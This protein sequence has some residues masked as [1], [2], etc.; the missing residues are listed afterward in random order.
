MV[1]LSAC[2]MLGLTMVPQAWAASDKAPAAKV[3][4][5]N[6]PLPKDI[7][8]ATSFAP[9]VK[10]VAPSVVNIYTSK[11]TR[12]NPRMHPLFNDPLFERFFGPG[13]RGQMQPRERTERSLGSGVIVSAD[14]YV[15]TANHV[16]EGAD[17]I[18]VALASGE[19]EFVAKLIGADPP[20]DIAVLK[21]QDGRQWPA[22]TLA[23]DTRLEVGDRVLAIG[24]PFGIGQTVT[25]G[26]VSGLERGGFGITGYENFIQTDAAINVGNSGG[27]L[28]DAAGRLVGIN[29][30]ILSPNAFGQG[31]GNVGVG[32][33]VPVGMAHYVME[34]LIVDGKVSR[35]YLGINPQQLTPDL[36]AQFSLPDESS[37]VLVGGVMPDG[38]ASK[39]GLKEGDVILEVNGKKVTEPRTLQ[40]VVAQTPPGTKVTLKVLRGER[41]KKPSEKTLSATLG[42]LP[43][44]A[45]ARGGR[46]RQMEPEDTT[47]D[48][49]DGVEV[50][51]LDPQVRRQQGI[52]NQVRGALVVNVDPNSNAAE[53]GLRPGDVILSINRQPVR[54]AD[55]AVT[56]SEQAKGEKIMLQVWSLAGPGQGFT[57]FLV[58]DNRKG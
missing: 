45:F 14:G 4:I 20:T 30:A 38:A 16:V 34:R 21:L 57:R 32:F 58:V 56:L 3:R 5:D 17:E 46:M 49:L 23:D 50:T 11:T 40:L 8:D 55:E 13:F 53:A 37:G 51:D 43:Q 24:N 42:T 35:G 52:P 15:L 9:I 26:I 36:A 22:I 25:M 44:D 47:Q 1:G 19:Q 10:K 7:K 48:S 41:G 54:N 31:G 27:A 2:I 18:K 6:A 28:V 12:E 39:A 33:A 29:T